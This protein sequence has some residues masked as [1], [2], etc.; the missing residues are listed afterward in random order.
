MGCPESARAHNDCLAIEYEGQSM[1]HRS[2]RG[3][4]VL[5]SALFG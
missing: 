1:G 5:N 4:P 3:S 2:R